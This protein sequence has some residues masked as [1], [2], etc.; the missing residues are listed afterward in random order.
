MSILRL[1]ERFADT[2]EVGFI[3]YARLGSAFTDAGTHPIL[4]LATP[5]N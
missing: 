1:D 3:G 5:A 2:L 4:K